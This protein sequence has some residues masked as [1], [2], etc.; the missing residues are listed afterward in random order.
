MELFLLSCVSLA[1]PD[2]GWLFPL[3]SLCSCFRGAKFL[4]HILEAMGAEAKLAQ[5]REDKNP[6]VIGRLGHDPQRPTVC[7]YG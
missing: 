5:A 2:C 6:V 1:V 4:M 3:L 7:F